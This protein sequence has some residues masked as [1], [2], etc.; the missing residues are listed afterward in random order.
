MYSQIS[1]I[2]DNHIPERLFDGYL[3]CLG[4]S[5]SSYGTCKKIF[6][7]REV[8]IASFEFSMFE[9][10]NSKYT[11]QVVV[12]VAQVINGGFGH[13]INTKFHIIRNGDLIDSF[14][15]NYNDIISQRED[16][17][18]FSS[19][20]DKGTIKFEHAV[21]TC[22]ECFAC[23]CRKE[24]GVWIQTVCFTELRYCVVIE[25][26]RANLPAILCC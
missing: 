20:K 24:Y 17:V 5:M 19:D 11:A 26:D 8:Y 9:Q 12:D 18:D 10:K 15:I 2:K 23:K 7:N 4:S 21:M 6:K 16:E 3:D 13:I 1:K 22:L 25:P 14:S